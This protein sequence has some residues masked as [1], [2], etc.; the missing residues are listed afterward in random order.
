MS[1]PALFEDVAI[2]QALAILGSEEDREVLFGR[3]HNKGAATLNDVAE[4]FAIPVEYAG[5]LM[6]P[7]WKPFRDRMLDL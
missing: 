1:R 2:Y 6:L 4:R 3:Y 5:Y 7:N